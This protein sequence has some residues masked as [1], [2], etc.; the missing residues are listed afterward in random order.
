VAAT[1][2]AGTLLLLGQHNRVEFLQAIT[3]ILSNAFLLRCWNYTIN[4][5][6][7]LK[8]SPHLK[9]HGASSEEN[10]SAL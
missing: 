8:F 3:K 4:A 2:C 6:S 10:S 7:T 9:K 1:V 5:I